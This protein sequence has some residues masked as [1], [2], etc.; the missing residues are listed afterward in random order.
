MAPGA[1]TLQPAV[2]YLTIRALAVPAILIQNVLVGV[3]LACALTRHSAHLNSSAAATTTTAA[4]AAATTT[5][6]P[7]LTPLHTVRTE[8]STTFHS[9]PNLPVST[10]SCRV[11]G[12]QGH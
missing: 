7:F 5:T 6:T 10:P 9:H 1:P 4:A 11:A 3:S 8:G 2:E 12:N